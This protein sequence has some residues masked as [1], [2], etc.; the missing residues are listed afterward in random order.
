MAE[1]VWFMQPSVNSQNQ[2]TVPATFTLYRRFF[3]VRPDI[4][5]I[6]STGTRFYDSYDLSAHLNGSGQMVANSLADLCYRENRYGHLTSPAPFLIQSAALAP[7]SSSDP[8]FGEDV[9]LTNVLSFDIKVWD[10][11][12]PLRYDSHATTAV[13]GTPLVPSDY[14]YS[15]GAGFSPAIYGA[16][17]DLNYSGTVNSTYFSGPY[18]G[19]GQLSLLSATANS[20]YATYD[21]W[22]AGY[23]YYALAQPATAKEST[24]STMTA[25]MASMTPMS[26]PSVVH[27]TRCRL[28]GMQIEIRVWEP[29]T[30]QVREVTVAETFLPD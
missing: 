14:G 20:G 26:G 13:P 10:P 22:P 7:F 21:L 23:E 12:V 16:Y 25:R 8:R 29:T 18:Y 19:N 9:V 5:P 6:N 1:V 24:V 11:L 15:G 27:R 30:Q 17:V 3:L 2:A 28:R 4:G